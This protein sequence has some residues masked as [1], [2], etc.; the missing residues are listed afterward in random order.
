[1][2]TSKPVGTD[3]IYYELIAIKLNPR[4][5]NKAPL[6]GGVIVDA[7][8]E[9]NQ[10]SGSPYP[11]VSM[12]MNSTGTKIW[13]QLTKEA[14]GENASKK[15]EIAV[16]LDGYVYSYP[17]VNDEIT[18]GNTQITG[19]FSTQEADDLVN[20]LSSGKISVPVKILS[21]ELTD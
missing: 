8:K 3:G 21:F 13:A 20:V 12:S 14:A 6:D 15:D 9:F 11:H 19:R 16:V 10:A 5:E 18:S 4:Y 17:T 2:W 1:L 7:R